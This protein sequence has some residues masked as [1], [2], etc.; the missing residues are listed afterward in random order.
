MKP[1]HWTIEDSFAMHGVL[2]YNFAF[3]GLGHEVLRYDVIKKLGNE[4]AL[5]LFPVEY[6]PAKEYLLSYNITEEGL[7]TTS[8][9]QLGFN[10]IESTDGG[11]YIN[12]RI[13]ESIKGLLLPEWNSL[14]SNNWVISGNLTKSGKPII[15]NDPHLG[16]A[17]PGLWY[18]VTL[19]SKEEDIQVQGFALPGIPLIGLGHNQFVAWGATSGI[20]DSLDTYF[21]KMNETSYLVNNTIW[22]H[23]ETEEHIIPIRGKEPVRHVV[24]ISDFGPLLNVTLGGENV[25]L[26]VKWTYHQN[27]ERNQPFKAIYLMNTAKSVEEFHTAL[28]Y[29]IVPGF[30][31]VV[32]DVQG[33][34]ALALNA[35]VPIRSRGYGLLP[36]N[37]SNGLNYWNG[38][39]PFENQYYVKNPPQGFLYS[40]NERVDKRNLY[41]YSESY[42]LGYRAKRISQ[43]LANFTD[44]PYNEPWDLP[45]VHRL[46]ADVKSLSATEMLIPLISKLNS[47]D[48]ISKLSYPIRQMIEMLASWDYVID[49]SRAEPL[50]FTTWR[51]LFVK[52]VLMDELGL[53]DAVRSQ[54]GGLGTITRYLAINQSAHWF[55]DKSTPQKE[56]AID[57]AILAL[58]DSYEY[59]STRYGHNIRTWQYGKAHKIKFEHPMGGVLPFLNIGGEGFN[60]TSLTVNAMEG[61]WLRSNGEIRYE[62]AYGPSMH[63]TAIVSSEWTDVLI[64]YPPGVS[65]NFGTSNY[66]NLYL[67][68]RDFKYFSPLFDEQ[69]IRQEYSREVIYTNG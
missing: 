37:G 23:F 43:V 55:D 1:K 38:T 51:L 10:G 28:Q 68:W 2:S 62:Y 33:D 26:A 32:A 3:A 20:A 27:Y 57:M 22:K 64:N 12:Y 35:L 25:E 11:S 42:A 40:A 39:I 17:V 7:P 15:A 5:D 50:I 41:Y 65:G 34:I 24:R 48:I 53:R 46:Q 4:R 18:F 52:R 54:Y 13:D 56:S 49:S 44:F 30:N 59:L 45:M 60:G 16:L 63:F 6:E 14:A 29:L 47:T 58:N 36:Q 61:P 69:R 8:K 31:W 9:T 21:L 66:D 19:I 67:E